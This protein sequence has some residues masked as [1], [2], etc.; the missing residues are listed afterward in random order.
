MFHFLHI[1]PLDKKILLPSAY[2][3]G[4]VICDIK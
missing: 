1:F 2:I 3:I 4:K